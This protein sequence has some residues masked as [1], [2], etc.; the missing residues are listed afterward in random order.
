MLSRGILALRTT[1]VGVVQVDPKKLLE[2][3]IRREL[4]NRVATLLQQV[5]I[6]NPKSK[7]RVG[8]LYSKINLIAKEMEG[9]RKSFEYI[10][11]YINIPGLR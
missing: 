1:L 7:D 2:E 11:D 5:F 9:F 6:F 10:E 3:G 4:V 8:D